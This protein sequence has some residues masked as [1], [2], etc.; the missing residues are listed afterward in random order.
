MIDALHL[1]T[2]LFGIIMLMT[3]PFND[4]NNPRDL[5]ARYFTMT[6]YYV[7]STY[8]KMEN[9]DCMQFF[10]IGLL[11]TFFFITTTDLPVCLGGTLQILSLPI[12]KIALQYV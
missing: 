1:T 7:S 3:S 9:F 8:S 12:D 6:R 11:V 2:S 5:L 10:F 4:Q